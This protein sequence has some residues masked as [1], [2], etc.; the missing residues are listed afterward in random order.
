MMVKIM[1][2]PIE[3]DGLGVPLFLETPTCSFAR[4]FSSPRNWW[5]GKKH[6]RHIATLVGCRPE[7]VNFQRENKNQPR[8]KP[9]FP[10][11]PGCLIGILIMVYFGLS[12]F[13]VIVTTRTISCLVGD[14]YK[15]SF[16]TISGKGENPRF[17]IIPT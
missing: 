17:M 7:T 13:P 3:M 12:P 8:R 15:L 5:S 4:F 14:S 10:L 16:A 6:V 1:E 2:N 9:A 11:N